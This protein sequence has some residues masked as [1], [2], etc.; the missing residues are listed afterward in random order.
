MKNGPEAAPGPAYSI[1]DLAKRTGVKVVTIRYYEKI[2]MLPEPPRTE[3]GQRLY[4][5]DHLRRLS[6]IRRSRE[7]GFSLGEIAALLT[8][9]NSADV[10]CDQVKALTLDHM[11]GIRRKIADLKRMERILK[12]MAAQCDRGDRGDLPDCPILDS[13]AA[14]EGR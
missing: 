7:L 8:L 10:S 9:E 13:L 11:Q 3:G 6:F 2:A 4:R 14:V 12:D 5:H 1:G